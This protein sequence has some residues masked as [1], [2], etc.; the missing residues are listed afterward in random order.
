MADAT[1]KGKTGEAASRKDYR[2]QLIIERLT[3][4][5]QGADLSHNKYVQWGVETEPEA[6]SAF[7]IESGEFVTEV[8]FIPHPKIAMSG[9][10]P[11]GLLP[12][13]GVLEIKCPASQTHGE[14][15]RSEKIPGKYQKQM[16]WQ[17]ACTGRGWGKFVS[18]DPRFNRGNRLLIINFEPP[19][20]A[21]E[22]LEAEAELF[23]SEVAADEL[24][25]RNRK[26]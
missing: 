24:W 11:D 21:I 7:E 3:G 22:S 25:L 26:G 16:L 20:A 8:G 6:R 5:A 12:G 2:W 19:A 23:L 15:L 1:A 14:V 18:Y 4:K 17:M 10:S 9:A 13:G